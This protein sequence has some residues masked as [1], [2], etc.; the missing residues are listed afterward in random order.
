MMVFSV[1]DGQLW[2]KEHTK[3]Q[4]LK[5]KTDKPVTPTHL[6]TRF[7]ESTPLKSRQPEAS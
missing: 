2:H 6:Q 4:A 3:S 7:Q 1:R 5:I